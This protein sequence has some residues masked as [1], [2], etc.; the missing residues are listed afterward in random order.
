MIRN[1]N[2]IIHLRYTTP[3]PVEEH[4]TRVNLDD[5]NEDFS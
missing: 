4:M 3:N 2:T 1:V 5:C